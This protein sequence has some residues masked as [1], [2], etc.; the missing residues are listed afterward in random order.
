MMNI[1]LAGACLSILCEVT[2]YITKR[3]CADVNDVLFNILGIIVG[4]VLTLNV[5]WSKYQDFDFLLVRGGS[6]QAKSKDCTK[7]RKSNYKDNEI[8]H[9]VKTPFCKSLIIYLYAER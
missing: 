6:T 4:V 1:V 2:Q 5:R 8:G 7:K 9:T 3:G